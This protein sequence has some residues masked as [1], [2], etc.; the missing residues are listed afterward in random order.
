MLVF[1]DK[2]ILVTININKSNPIL[3]NHPVT[4]D[5][6]YNDF[7]GRPVGLAG[8][9]NRVS[10]T[11]ESPPTFP[12]ITPEDKRKMD[13]LFNRCFFN[14]EQWQKNN[15]QSASKLIKQYQS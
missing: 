7:E 8:R 9:V 15:N 14:A 6:I 4:D 10:N 2:K 1:G 13:M 12:S 5:R 11:V 3:Q